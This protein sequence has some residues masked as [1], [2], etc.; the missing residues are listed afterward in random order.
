MYSIAINHYKMQCKI[1]KSGFIRQNF[2]RVLVIGMIFKFTPVN[3]QVRIG[4]DNSAAVQSGAMLELVSSTAGAGFLPPKVALTSTTVWTLAGT[5]VDGMVVYNTS[6]TITGGTS[7]AS[8]GIYVW[9]SGKWNRMV[10]E[11]AQAGLPKAVLRTTIAQGGGAANGGFIAN[12]SYALKHD[13]VEL[14]RGLSL[15]ADGAKITILTAGFYLIS[16]SVSFCDA[17]GGSGSAIG[18]RY[19]SIVINGNYDSGTYIMNGTGGIQIAATAFTSSGLNSMTTSAFKYLAVGDTII[20]DVFQG[21]T[22]TNVI[23]QPS[24]GTMRLEATMFSN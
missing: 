12:T 16:T 18:Q 1:K 24:T 10:D 4:P 21:T 11:A 7:G 14:N 20:C 17:P 6:P 23:T 2:L 3:A 9:Y 15:S 22:Y 19:T 13:V 8:V 5:A